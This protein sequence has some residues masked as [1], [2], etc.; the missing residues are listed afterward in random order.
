MCRLIPLALL[1]SVVAACGR[2]EGREVALADTLQIVQDVPAD[3]APAPDSAPAA[4]PAAA[5]KAKPAA[6]PAAAPATPPLSPAEAADIAAKTS[7]LGIFVYAAKGQ[8]KDQQAIDQKACYTWAGSQTGVDP[9]KVSVN[10]DSAAAAGKAAADSATAGGGIK[11]AARGAAGGAV[12]GAI[13]GDAGAGAGIGA[14][15]GVAKGRKAMKQAGAQGSQQ[16]VAQAES[17]A[18]AKTATFKNA[19]TACLE[20]KGYTVK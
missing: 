6:K 7:K 5:R 19:M 2:N 14:V 15:V 20:G 11:G 3:T 9:E 4:T 10:T 13:A 8:S 1:L 18:A 17:Q 12:V 16:A